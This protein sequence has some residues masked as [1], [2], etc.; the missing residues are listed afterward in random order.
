L[1]NQNKVCIFTNKINIVMSYQTNVRANKLNRT[2]KMA[3]YKARRRSGDNTRLAETTGYSVGHVS[4]VVNGNRKVNEV[5][6]NAMYNIA[7]RRVKN[8][9]LAN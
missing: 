5:L 4:N 3:F 9:E 8:S 6:A 1:E 2:A 7:R